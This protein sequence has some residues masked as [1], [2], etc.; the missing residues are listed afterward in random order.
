MLFL[1]L[2]VE[3]RSQD[4]KAH[5]GKPSASPSAEE[6]DA[7]RDSS[8]VMSGVQDATD[9]AVEDDIAPDEDGKTSVPYELGLKM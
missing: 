7:L 3:G 4:A 5:D 8:Q 1:E 6:Q 9:V 2:S